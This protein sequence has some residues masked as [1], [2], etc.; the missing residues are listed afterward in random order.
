M[1]VLWTLLKIVI[2][3]AVALYYILYNRGTIGKL[4]T[5]EMLPPSWDK[6]QREAFLDDLK[7]RREKSKWAMLILIP[8]IVVFGYKALEITLFSQFPSLF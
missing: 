8:M 2:T 1:R 5:P 4:P 6:A 3:L 7:A